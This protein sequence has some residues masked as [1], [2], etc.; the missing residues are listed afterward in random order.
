MAKTKSRATQLAELIEKFAPLIRDAFFQAISG[1]KNAATLGDVIRAI[2]EGDPIKAFAA[3]GM[4]N[5]AMRSV[6]ASI[7]QAF[8]TGG[9]M[10]ANTFPK[11]TGPTGA[12]TVFRFDVRNSRAEAWLRDL[13]SSLVTNINEEQLGNIRGVMTA[14][15]KAGT[16]PRG[17][18]LDIVG[19]IDPVT[20]S[21]TGGI[22]GLS[23]PQA[24]WVTNARAELAEPTAASNWFTR[25]RR[26]RR[27][28]SIVQKSIDSGVPLDN[29][30]VNK[31][32][33]RYS[34]S[35]L[36]LRGE[37]IA[38]TEA[39]AS[40]NK[41]QDE[42]FQQAIDEGL[43]APEAVTRIWDAAG[44]NRV[45]DTHRDMD[46][47][48]VGMNEPFHSPNGASMMFPG[49]ASLGAPPEE[50]INCRCKVR[51]SVDFLRGVQ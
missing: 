12:K 13:S 22:V 16:N 3:L 11:L 23:R 29:A 47:Q 8:E 37:T 27:F 43:I 32:V 9:V 33:T 26:D 4:N 41:S 42:A 7:E 21:R 30:T 14:G 49:D 39:L 18:A 1:V 36:Q 15:V 6:T 48:A 44:D 46:G 45:R 20:G 35:L 19:R 25:E 31:L 28:D 40:L 38:R 17:I 10:V 24:Q 34:D 51:V 5:A 50:I 2:E